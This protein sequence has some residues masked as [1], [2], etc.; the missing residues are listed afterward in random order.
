MH[1]SERVGKGPQ[2]R[3][4]TWWLQIS[5]AAAFSIKSMALE[6]SALRLHS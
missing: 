4:Q 2:L 1:L 3:T 6:A 5:S